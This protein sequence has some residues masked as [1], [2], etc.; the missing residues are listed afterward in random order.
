MIHF[1]LNST[2]PTPWHLTPLMSRCRW[3]LTSMIHAKYYNNIFLLP[4][5][6]KTPPSGN[7][8]VPYTADYASL[9]TSEELTTQFPYSKHSW[10]N[11]TRD[12]STLS[13][14]PPA[15]A[16]SSNTSTWSDNRGIFKKKGKDAMKTRYM[17][18]YMIVI[19]DAII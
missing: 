16:Q 6:R 2:Q 5:V 4:S 14:I 18:T 13:E 1:R 19:Q 12:Y 15:S 10:S 9:T 7:N 3:N 17:S 8:G 11:S